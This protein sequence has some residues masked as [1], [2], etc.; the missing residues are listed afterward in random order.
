MLGLW[1][2]LYP[3]PTDDDHESHLC[4]GPHLVSP[5]G[6]RE[7]NRQWTMAVRRLRSVEP[8]LR[9]AVGE[10]DPAVDELVARVAALAV[11]VEKE[12]VR[13]APPRPPLG[14]DVTVVCPPPPPP[15]RHW[16][17]GTR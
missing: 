2:V 5:V 14:P 6:W 9:D 3:R 11:L 4:A 10:P 12:R 15:G 17:R 13:R 16:R 7:R 1:W 8:L